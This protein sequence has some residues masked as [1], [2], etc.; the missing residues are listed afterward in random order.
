[1]STIIYQYYILYD[2]L[3]YAVHC[4]TVLYAFESNSQPR[5]E[6]Y[7][8]I[9]YYSRSKLYYTYDVRARGWT[10]GA[11]CLGDCVGAS[12]ELLELNRRDFDLGFGV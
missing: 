1:M 6:E 4:W 10:H 7:H 2:I 9:L 8:S 5:E 12:I 11:L 3:D